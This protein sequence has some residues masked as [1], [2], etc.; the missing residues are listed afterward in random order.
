[1][2]ATVREA[3]DTATRASSSGSGGTGRAGGPL[4]SNA[5]PVQRRQSS[6][7]PLTPID[8]VATGRPEDLDPSTTSS[9]CRDINVRSVTDSTGTVRTPY[10]GPDTY[11]RAGVAY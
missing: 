7:R 4:V 10:G 11:Y 6:R 9:R 2:T 3:D 5:M 1:M 8:R